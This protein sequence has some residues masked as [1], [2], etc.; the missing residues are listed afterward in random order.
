M[1]SEQR[2]AALIAFLAGLSACNEQGG[3]APGAVSEGEAQAL[4]EAAEMLDER[5]LP[6]GVLPPLDM[7]EDGEATP[8]PETPQEAETE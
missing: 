4:E 3:S 1:R 5:Q 7:A 6:E 2:A 8:Q